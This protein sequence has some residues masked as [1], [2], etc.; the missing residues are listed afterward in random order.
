MILIGLGLFQRPAN[1]RRWLLAEYGDL[2]AINA[3]WKTSY[4]TIDAIPQPDMTWNGTA[5]TAS[6]QAM[7]ADYNSFKEW[8]SYRFLKNQA[9]AIRTAD[10]GHM[11]TAG[12]LPGHPAIFWKGSAK[13]HPGIAAK[14]L[15]F[16]DYETIHIYTHPA[17]QK[18]SPGPF[19]YAL[20]SGVLSARFGHHPGKPLIAEE[21]GHHVPDYKES[22]DET[23][24]IVYALVGHV[25]G[26]QLWLLTDADNVPGPLDKSFQPNDWGRAWM[27]LAEPDGRVARL[28]RERAKG[29]T[30]YTLHRLSGEAPIEDSQGNRLLL[31]WD[32]ILQPVEFKWPLNPAIAKIRTPPVRTQ[33]ST[34]SWKKFN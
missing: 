27:K 32:S 9:D 30:T 28:P 34:N 14:E 1:W 29:Q 7:I 18:P 3:S 21:I 17:D 6:P 5:Y 24:N 10:Q 16:L 12:L 26:F 31:A 13:Y 19:T 11:V 22:L 2:A 15:D 20:H 4:A 8:V 25:S 33:V 23:F